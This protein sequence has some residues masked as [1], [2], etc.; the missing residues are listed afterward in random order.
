MLSL[1][2]WPKMKYRKFM[3]L[4]SPRSGT[5][6]LR[7]SLDGHPNVVCLTEMFN[8][9]YTTDNYAYDENTAE[10]T[11]LQQ[12]VFRSYQPEVEAVGFCIHR[13]G[14]RFGN[15]RRLW[16]LLEGLSDLYVISL[17]RENLLRR[18]L[19]FQLR[20]HQDI[21]TNPPSPMEFDRHKLTVDFQRQSGKIHEFDDRFRRHPVWQVSYEQLS[22]DYLKTTRSIQEFLEVPHYPL[23]PGTSKRATPPLSEAIENYA[24][25]KRYFTGT[26]WEK[27]FDD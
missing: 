22:N 13:V 5:H 16:S 1:F 23:K 6:M 20:T 7:T 12:F 2:T 25:L 3:V 24:D 8:P 17:R 10:E 18:Y 14:A 11:I 15:W 26:E 21:R 27:F 9:D 19:S 4:S